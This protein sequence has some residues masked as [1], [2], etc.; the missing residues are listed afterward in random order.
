ML[1]YVHQLVAYIV[2]LLFGAGQVA[3]SEFL[4]CFCWKQTAA[5]CGYGSSKSE[6]KPKQWDTENLYHCKTEQYNLVKLKVKVNLAFS[7]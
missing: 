4:D 3:Y 5:C 2:G 6:P 7:F 1:R